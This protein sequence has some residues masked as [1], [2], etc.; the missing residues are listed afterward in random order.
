MGYKKI[1]DA[2]LPGE[3]LD[4]TLRAAL[5]PFGQVLDIQNEMRARTYRYAV[6]NGVDRL[7]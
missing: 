7:T 1:R 6:A 5:A 4:D 3:V 2:N